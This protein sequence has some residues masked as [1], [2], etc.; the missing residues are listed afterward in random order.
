MLLARSRIVHLLTLL[1]PAR[2][3]VAGAP[4]LNKSAYPATCLGVVGGF[5]QLRCDQCHG[6]QRYVYGTI[7]VPLNQAK[8]KVTLKDGESIDAPSTRLKQQCSTALKK[9]AECKKCAPYHPE[10]KKEAK[11]QVRPLLARRYGSRC[12]CVVWMVVG[13]PWKGAHHRNCTQSSHATAL[14]SSRTSLAGTCAGCGA[15]A[16]CVA[17]AR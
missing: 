10:C 3:A 4:K 9:H 7:D 6:D 15:C 8:L 5:V 11:G 16:G 17:C 13:G 2:V 12:E 1:C 14:G